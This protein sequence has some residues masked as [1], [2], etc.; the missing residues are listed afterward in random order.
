MAIKQE[1]SL[2]QQIN[3]F[4]Q[5]FEQEE[6]AQYYRKRGDA[7]SQEGEARANLMNAQTDMIR[8]KI[9]AGNLGGGGG[10]NGTNSFNATVTAGP[11]KGLPLR[12]LPTTA[13]LQALQDEFADKLGA[14]DEST[15]TVDTSKFTPAQLTQYNQLGLALN[16]TTT[17]PYNR[18]RIIQAANV[19]KSFN[20]ID[21]KPFAYYA[22]TKGK[23]RLANDKGLAAMGK[24]PDMYNRYMVS[25]GLMG[26]TID[27]LTQYWG[28]SITQPAVE[29]KEK[30]FNNDSWTSNPTAVF[31]LYNS[32]KNLVNSEVQENITAATDPNFI[33]TATENA[34]PNI[35]GAKNPV[36]ST[37]NPNENFQDTSPIQN[38]SL[39]SSPSKGSV[40]GGSTGRTYTAQDINQLA[41]QHS[42]TV[43]QVIQILMEQG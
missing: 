19:L 20:S 42:K 34:P 7:M 11:F 14:Y 31:N 6:R 18:K 23:A 10:G 39:S 17:D 24:A 26:A 5:Q 3:S 8:E 38:Y 28:A 12:S 30:M 21:M 41:Q 1:N 25:Q 35:T 37:L 13:R 33:N 43:P 40:V 16:K 29:A 9:K 36:F 4:P 27:Q 15:D 2:A 32:M 22:G